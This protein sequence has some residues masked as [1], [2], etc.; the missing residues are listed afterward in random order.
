MD[1]M[2]AKKWTVLPDSDLLRYCILPRDFSLFH[3]T[4]EDSEEVRANKLRCLKEAED[5]MELY[6][7]VLVPAI[8]GPKLWHPKIRHFESMTVA[9]MPNNS[10]QNRITCSTEAMTCLT[11][12]NN[13]G[14]W[15]AQRRF[16]DEN[17][18]NDDQMPRY[19]SKKPD[20]NQEFKTLYSDSGVGQAAWGGW[21]TESKYLLRTLTT[22]VLESRRQNVDRH[23]QVDMECVDRLFNKYKHLHKSESKTAKKQK[24]DQICSDL[25]HIERSAWIMEV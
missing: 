19:N 3:I 21:S 13:R 6:T 14:K 4:D 20:E 5:L 1:F 8:A 16:L 9:T 17:P 22:E 25:E 12:M 18:G 23:V 10:T 11:Y 15:M 24:T 7:E 2:K